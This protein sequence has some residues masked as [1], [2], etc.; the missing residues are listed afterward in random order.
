[1]YLSLKTGRIYDEESTVGYIIREETVLTGE[2]YKNGLV[3]IKSEGTKVSK[4]DN[5]FRYYSN[6]ESSLIEKIEAL[7]IEIQEA[8]EGQTSVYSA[9][10][11][12]LDK[13]IEEYIQ[14]ILETNDVDEIA[15]YKSN[16]S[17]RLIKKAKIAGEYS[18]SGSYISSLIEERRKYEEELNDGQEYITADMSGVVSYRVD[19]LEEVLTPDNFDNINEELLESYNLKTGQMISQSKEAGKIVN[20]YECYI[21]VFLESD[22]A[23]ESEVRRYSNAE[24]SRC[25]RNKC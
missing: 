25:N 2:N 16:I 3:E 22:E 11:Q 23:K 1:M 24:T 5:V 8:L 19:G 15:E 10:I 7:D 13:Q 17:E 12:V 20:N 14:K 9:D 21:T 4:G 18:P 6:N